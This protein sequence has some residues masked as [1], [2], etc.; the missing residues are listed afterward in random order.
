MLTYR[1]EYEHHWGSKSYYTQLRLDALSPEDTEEFLSNLLGDDGSLMSLKALLP[2][3]GTPFFLEEIVRSLIE[4]SLLEGKEGNYR[5]VSPLQGVR[6]P[7]SVQS[8][9]AARIDRLP[10]RQKQ[11]LQA[12]SVIGKDVPHALLQPVAGLEEDELRR[13]LAK[14]REAEF[15]YEARLFPDLEYAFKHALTQEVVY[16]SQLV[17]ERRALHRQLVNVI[18][19]LYPD[20]LVEQ[21]EQ[22]A[23]HAIHGELWEKAVKYARQAGNKA[24][25]RWALKDARTWFEKALVVLERLPESPFTLELGFDIRLELRPVLSMLGE[26]R[27]GRERLQEAEILAEQLKDDRRRGRVCAFVTNSHSQLGELEQALA[28]GTR[29]LQIAERVE[30]LRTGILARNYLQQLHYFRGDYQSVVEQAFGTIAVLPPEWVYETFG[31]AGPVSLDARG[32]LV[33]SLAELGRFAEAAG[34][35]A[36]AIQLAEHTNHAFTPGMAHWA[37]STFHLFKGEWEKAHSVIEDWVATVRAGSVFLMLARAVAF[38]AWTSAQRGEVNQAL[39]RIR[40]SEQLLDQLGS[41]GIVG[42]RSWTYHALGRA[43]LLLGKLGEARRLADRALESSVGHLGFAAHAMG[44]LA[45]ITAHPDWLDVEYAEAQYRKAL[46]IAA[47]RSMRPLVAHC[48]RGLA[49]LYLRRGERHRAREHSTKAMTMYR[50]MDMRFW[51]A[52][53]A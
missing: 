23:H 18:E 21:F 43:C 3:N 15:L 45:D 7:P 44:L 40:E 17:E 19:C 29:A 13:V 9:L 34:P 28:S 46:A 8:I 33:L 32:W 52:H 10:A 35:L 42:V 39:N 26:V 22:L 1:P 47:P 6:A 20:R 30:D 5:L 48:H 2:T 50:V 36:E 31:N 51:L 49:G 24:A 41:R 4:T 37:A 12:A 38:S 53:S 16:G 25:A 14:L 11:V 27:L